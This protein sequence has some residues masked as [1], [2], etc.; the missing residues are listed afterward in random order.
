M[1]LDDLA[2]YVEGRGDR[3]SVFA[4]DSGGS[5]EDR[6]DEVL[7]YRLQ[8]LYSLLSL[9]F[10]CTSAFLAGLYGRV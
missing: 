9:T 6:P 10:F 3:K 5:D 1:D 8:I 2:D 7:R 4:G